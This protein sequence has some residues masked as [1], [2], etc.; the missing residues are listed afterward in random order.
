MFCFIDIHFYSNSLCAI[1]NFFSPNCL[2]LFP[3][4][5]SSRKI[6]DPSQS[7]LGLA[8]QNFVDDETP[9]AETVVA[10][11]LSNLLGVLSLVLT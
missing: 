4:C 7:S 9:E 2:E 3:A 11:D 10:G 1:G 8:D 5:F 6:F